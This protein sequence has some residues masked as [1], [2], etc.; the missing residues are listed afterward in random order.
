MTILPF[1]L[2]LDCSQSH[3]DHDQRLLLNPHALNLTESGSFI[4]L[5]KCQ[6]DLEVNGYIKLEQKNLYSQGHSY[7]VAADG[8]VDGGLQWH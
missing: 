1:S 6:I 8:A 5:K 4:P 7:S 2:F 3:I